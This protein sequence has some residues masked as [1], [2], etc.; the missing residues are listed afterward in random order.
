MEILGKKICGRPAIELRNA[1]RAFVNVV[2]YGD[3]KDGQYIRRTRQLSLAF[4]GS[5]LG[6]SKK[7]ASALHRCLVSEG[8]IDA[9]RLIPTAKGMSL[10]Q[11]KARN[12]ISR[13]RAK[14]ILKEFLVEVR[15]ANSKPGARVFVEQAYVFG[16][17]LTKIETVGDIDL[18][19]VLSTPNSGEDFE[20]WG[21]LTNKIKISEYL[22]FHDEFDP[23]V[24][25]ARKKRIYNRSEK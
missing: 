21:R 13:T 18:L 22:S 16:S 4:L 17:Y 24:A 23:V 25:T 9:E 2:P 6:L 10:A 1:F 20:R 5:E 3:F 15:K 19:V 8:F 7:N 14:E 12:R 11:A